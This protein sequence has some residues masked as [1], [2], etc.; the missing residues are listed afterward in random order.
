MNARTLVL[1]LVA[2]VLAGVAYMT[3]R[4]SPEEKAERLRQE[5]AV[6]CNEIVLAGYTGGAVS[7]E[8]RAK[9]DVATRKYNKFMN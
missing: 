2:L 4:E 5:M 3:Y 6:A 9:C 1:G 8:A 7:S